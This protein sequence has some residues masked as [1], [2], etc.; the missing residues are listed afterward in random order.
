MDGPGPLVHVGTEHEG[1]EI[2]ERLRAAGIKCAVEPMPD[3]NSLSGIWGGQAPTVLTVLVNESDMDDARAVVAKY[4]SKPREH[5]VSVCESRTVGDDPGSQLGTG[6]EATCECGWD[7]PI[8]D[9]SDEAFEDAYKHD[10]N[11]SAVIVRAT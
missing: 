10:S 4:E 2:C 1:D 3:P 8:R 5:K 7:G 6:F 9:T 11:V